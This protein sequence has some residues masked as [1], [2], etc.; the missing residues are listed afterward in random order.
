MPQNGTTRN[1]RKIWFKWYKILVTVGP[2]PD[3]LKP[4]V[5]D[6]KRKKKAKTEI[7]FS[8]NRTKLSNSMAGG[9]SLILRI[10]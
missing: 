2:L 9:V 5:W 1:V 6:K 4:Y 10:N 3:I 7:K 8:S